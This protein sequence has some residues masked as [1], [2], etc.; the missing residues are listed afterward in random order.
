M[1]E[2]IITLF[3]ESIEAKMQSGEYLAPLLVDASDMLVHCLLQERKILLAGNGVSAA[4]AQIMTASLVNRFE[5]ERPS[6][7]AICLGSDLTTQTAIANDSSFNDI[8]AKQVRSLGQ[9]GDVLIVITT[10]GNCSNL[11]QAV[12]TAHDREMDVIVLSGKDGGDLASLTYAQDI[13]LRVPLE[14]CTRIHE[15]HLLSI[16]CLCDLIDKQL[17]GN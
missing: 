6:L 4:Q 14:S 11:L 12:S 7:P 1:E 17:F 16:F 10:S 13:E 9:P 2:H 3:H 8:Y 15:V 5:Q